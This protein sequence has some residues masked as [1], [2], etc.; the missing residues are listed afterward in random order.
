[1]IGA[2]MKLTLPNN[3]GYSKEFKIYQGDVAQDESQIEVPAIQATEEQVAAGEVP[4]VP[5]HITH[6]PPGSDLPMQGIEQSGQ[7][8][9]TAPFDT[10]SPV[11]EAAIT[12]AESLSPELITGA[13]EAPPTIAEP[14]VVSPAPAVISEDEKAFWKELELIADI[15]QKERELQ[16]LE[17]EY[18]F[19]KEAA[20][21]AKQAME[22]CQQT[23]RYRTNALVDFL[24]KRSMPSQPKVEKPA[25]VAANAEP[26]QAVA[27][28]P[29]V[30][31]YRELKTAESFKGL[32]G[33]GDKKLEALSD[34]CP[35]IGHIEKLRIEAAEEHKPFKSKLPKGF[36]D[37]IVSA[38]E[39]RILDLMKE[40]ENAKPA[41]PAVADQ[42]EPATDATPVMDR[43]LTAEEQLEIVNKFDARRQAIESKAKAEGWTLED[44]SLEDD[45]LPALKEGFEAY[46]RDEPCHACKFE[47]SEDQERWI[48]GWVL[49]KL[50][51]QFEA[52]MAEDKPVAE[53]QFA[54][55]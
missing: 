51:H 34:L 29:A 7:T 11:A 41:T 52:A 33:M 50:K 44:C 16:S 42:S 12:G 2:I 8:E 47:S 17:T 6:L 20:K 18:R 23:L 13:T 36:G 25:E 40:C 43:E 27:S 21:E 48:Q 54:T 31:D 4:V 32:K 5:G 28:E 53:D 15:A 46:N 30:A 49:A 55:I 22:A 1:M 3:V 14:T 35:T 10:E 9:Y 24:R 37:G 38:I 26:D 39:D 45:D 19:A